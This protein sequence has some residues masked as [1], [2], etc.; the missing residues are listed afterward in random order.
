MPDEDFMTTAD[1]V[2]L[3]V[4]IAGSGAGSLVVPGVG[5]DL[6]FGRLGTSRRV[7]FYDVR[8]RGRSDAVDGS[9]HVGL[10]VEIDD[11]EAVRTHVGFTQTSVLGWSYIGLVVALYAADHSRFVDRLVMVCPAPPSQ[12]LQPVPGVPAA[13]VL[14]RLSELATR[15]ATTDPVAFAREWRRIMTP[16][17]YGG[18]GRVRPPAGG[19]EY[20]VQRVA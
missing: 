15:R 20:V 7:A 8:N 18:P 1:G 2:R 4:R 6:D 13:D 16:T 12:S 11:V 17:A 5:A 14:E 3:F 10:P 19:S 9:G